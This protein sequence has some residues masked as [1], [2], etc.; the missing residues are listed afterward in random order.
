[1]SALPTIHAGEVAPQVIE[2]NVLPSDLLPSLSVVTS[3]A[4]AVEKPN[5]QGQRVEV[6]WAVTLSNQTATTLRGTHLFQ[7]GDLDVPGEYSAVLEMTTPAGVVR[8]EPSQFLV[9][10]K[11]TPSS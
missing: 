9:L 7:A 8:A 11:F 3:I 1:M 6:A 2:I 10:R 4:L 5:S